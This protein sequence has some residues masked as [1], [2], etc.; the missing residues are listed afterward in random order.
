MV[1]VVCAGRPD[2]QRQWSSSPACA[3]AGR[4]L[5]LGGAARL[6]GLA[7]RED[8]RVL[9]P[10]GPVLQLVVVDLE[11]LGH[12]A[13][14]LAVEVVVC[15]ALVRVCLLDWRQAGRARDPHSVLLQ[16]APVPV[17]AV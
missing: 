1:V 6:H 12:L 13:P 7:A 14:A 4:R 16:E 5:S 17:V 2:P 15:A 8:G 11:L 3:G 10:L 9:R